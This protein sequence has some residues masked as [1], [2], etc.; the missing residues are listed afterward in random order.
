MQHAVTSACISAHVDMPSGLQ[1]PQQ[2]RSENNHGDRPCAPDLRRLLPDL[3][4]AAIEKAW[5]QHAELLVA[6]LETDCRLLLQQTLCVHS[7]C[8]PLPL[9]RDR[10]RV[11]RP[12]KA[13]FFRV[14]TYPHVSLCAQPRIGCE[15][16][17][18]WASKNAVV[19]SSLAETPGNRCLSRS[20]R[21]RLRVKGSGARARANMATNMRE[22]GRRSMARG[23]G[24]RWRAAPPVATAGQLYSQAGATDFGHGPPSDLVSPQV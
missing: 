18:T 10:G 11:L 8:A 4:G 15:R 20:L 1:D 19:P 7:V 5:R 6:D 13:D 9:P 17:R 22:R 3:D 14:C 23:G 21:D 12:Q 24:E 2:M 16:G